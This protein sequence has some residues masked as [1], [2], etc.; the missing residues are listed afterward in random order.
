MVLKYTGNNCSGSAGETLSLK[1]KSERLWQYLAITSFSE[2][3]AQFYDRTSS[4]AD[5]NL[6]SRKNNNYRLTLQHDIKS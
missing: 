3:L 2:V 5:T 6:R 4:L 1:V